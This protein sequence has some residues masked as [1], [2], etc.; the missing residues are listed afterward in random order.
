MTVSPD[1]QILPVPGECQKYPQRFTVKS[2]EYQL[3]YTFTQEGS[4][5]FPSSP[6]LR[7]AKPKKRST[8]LPK[9][10]ATSIFSSILCQLHDVCL[11]TYIV[12]R[13]YAGIFARKPDKGSCT[14]EKK[15]PH[16]VLK[17]IFVLEGAIY[18]RRCTAADFFSS[19]AFLCIVRQKTS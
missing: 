10:T 4:P 11:I 14:I 9:H 8:V 2:K 19:K 17:N 15:A 1:E 16:I 18:N 6:L 7:D 13:M 5:D 3:K 12:L